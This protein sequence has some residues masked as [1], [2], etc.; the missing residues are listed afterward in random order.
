[1]PPIALKAILTPTNS[2]WN[3]LTLHGELSSEHAALEAGKQA[4]HPAP[5]AP[6]E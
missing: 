6:A 5:D 3:S 4:V 2:A 1:M